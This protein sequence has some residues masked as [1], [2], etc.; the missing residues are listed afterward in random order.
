MGMRYLFTFTFYFKVRFLLTKKDFHNF[1]IFGKILLFGKKWVFSP[2][3]SFFENFEKF[4]F[5]VKNGIFEIVENFSKF[6]I[7]GLMVTKNFFLKKS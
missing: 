3:F 4:R 1:D 2:F 5:L 6:S 7:F